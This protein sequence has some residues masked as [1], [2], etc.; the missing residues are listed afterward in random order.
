MAVGYMPTLGA[1]GRPAANARRDPAW[2]SFKAFDES[3][4]GPHGVSLEE[5]AKACDRD[6]AFGIDNLGE[7]L[8]GPSAMSS[9]SV[10]VLPV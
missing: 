3:V 7:E 4:R 1:T 6:R 10:P 9:L 5:S 2:F 8:G